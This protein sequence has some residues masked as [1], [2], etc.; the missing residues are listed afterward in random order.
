MLVMNN[1]VIA[2]TFFPSRKSD[3][4]FFIVAIVISTN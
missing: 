3:E 4:G 2:K 1:E